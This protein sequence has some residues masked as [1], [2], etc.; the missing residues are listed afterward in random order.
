MSTLTFATSTDFEVID[1]ANCALLFAIPKRLEQ[2]RRND[3][4]SFYC[5][6]GHA[7]HY[8]GKSELE[9]ARDELAKQKQLR[10]QAEAKAAAEATERAKAEDKL[11]R[12]KHR[13]AGGACP[14]CKRSFVKLAR[15]MATKHPGYAKAGG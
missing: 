11:R 14:C 12:T 4:E 2:A 13:I 3:H 7:N 6:N 8:P 10:E 1:C 15:H 5:P 9:K